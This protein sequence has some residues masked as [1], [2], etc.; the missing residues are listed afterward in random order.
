[1]AERAADYTRLGAVDLNLLVPLLALLEEGSVTA[2]AARVGMSQPAM[3]HALRRMRRMLKDDLLVR[4]GAGMA[5]TPRALELIGPLRRALRHTEE[6]VRPGPF[7]PATDRRVVTMA[8]TSSTAFQIG[9]QV[10]RLMAERAPHMALRLR[11]TPLTGPSDTVFTQDGVDVLLLPQAFATAHPRERLYDDRWVVITGP[12]VPS[13]SATELIERLPHV[14][15]DAA[16]AHRPRPYE[17]LDELGLRYEIRTRVSD[18][19]LGPYVVAEAGSVAFHREGVV[20]KLR[21]SLGLQVHEVP[22][23]IE[24]LGIDL[25]WN[26]WLADEELRS[27]LGAVLREAASAT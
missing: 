8:M 6:L 10:A 5:L 23:A 1:M 19:L 22:F 24:G 27:W 16:A 18:Q 12:Q 4:Q 7:E 11:T 25:V 15:F 2:A 9:G 14:V 26:P 21:R 13:A 3:S 20:A 17:V